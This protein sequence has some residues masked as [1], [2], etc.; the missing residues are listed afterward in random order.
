MRGVNQPLKALPLEPDSPTLLIGPDWQIAATARRRYRSPSGLSPLLPPRGPLCDWS[1][2]APVKPMV[3]AP[4]EDWERQSRLTEESDPGW[5]RSPMRLNQSRLVRLALQLPP[6]ATMVSS[7]A[8]LPTQPPR[9]RG[10]SAS[11]ATL[12]RPTSRLRRARP[13]GSVSFR[14]PC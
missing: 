14:R 4:S 11:G 6:A 1:K 5:Q 2:A 9:E 10:A 13:A 3:Q 7:L 12:G 8:V